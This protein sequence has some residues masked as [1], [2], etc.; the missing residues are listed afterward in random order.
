ERGPRAIQRRSD[1]SRVSQTQSPRSYQPGFFA[2]AT[3]LRPS[4]AD[5]NF[6]MR[7]NPIRIRGPKSRKRGPPRGGGAATVASKM[8]GSRRMAGGILTDAVSQEIC[9]PHNSKEN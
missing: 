2:G 3:E 7:R 9:R 5:V 8:S 4:L 6:R 1:V